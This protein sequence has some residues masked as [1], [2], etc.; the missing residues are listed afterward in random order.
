MKLKSSISEPLLKIGAALAGG[1]LLFVLVISIAT[2]TFRAVYSGRIFPNIQIGWVNLSGQA[3]IDA[4]DLLRREIQYPDQG[5]I[6]L[7]YDD[8]NWTATPAEL[9]LFFSP[10]FN[11]ELAFN[12]GRE[13]NIARRIAAQIQILR[14][15]LILAPQFVMDEK[16]GSEY[17][18]GIAADV[19]QPVM[20]ATLELDGLEVM[21]QPGQIGREMD[22]QAS[23]DVVGLQMQSMQDGSIPLIARAWAMRGRA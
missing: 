3:Q 16:T 18:V 15:G 12:T 10:Q 7:Q 6:I 4:A 1:I 14:H 13:G 20:E 19:N 8:L 23:L 17:L 5:E 21:V 11:A 9:G 2:T 22:I